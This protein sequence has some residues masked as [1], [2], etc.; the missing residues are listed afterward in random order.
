MGLQPNENFDIQDV[1]PPQKELLDVAGQIPGARGEKPSRSAKASQAQIIAAKADEQSAKI[2]MMP[3]VAINGTFA[4]RLDQSVAER[5]VSHR[6]AG[7][8]SVRR[9]EDALAI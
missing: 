7:L 5:M 4:N 2:N 9:P 6:G 1:E 3:H 8:Q